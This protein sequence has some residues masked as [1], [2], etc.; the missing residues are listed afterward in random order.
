MTVGTAVNTALMDWV[1]TATSLAVMLAFATA[2][3]SSST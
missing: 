2:V 1:T 3:V